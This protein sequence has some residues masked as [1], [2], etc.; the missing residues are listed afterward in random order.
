MKFVSFEVFGVFLKD[1]L[2]GI[3]DNSI[4]YGFS[5][6]IVKSA[7][8]DEVLYTCFWLLVR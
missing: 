4:L 6:G 3:F 8:Y 2:T 1:F 5:G 7:R